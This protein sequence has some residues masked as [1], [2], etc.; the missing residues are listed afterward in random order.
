MSNFSATGGTL[1]R[2]LAAGAFTNIVSAAEVQWNRPL[3]QFPVTDMAAIVERL[4]DGIGCPVRAT[5]LDNRAVGSAAQYRLELSGLDRNR[6][7]W[8]AIARHGAA[9]FDRSIEESIADEARLLGSDSIQQILIFGG[10]S[11]LGDN[12]IQIIGGAE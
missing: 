6:L 8:A 3:G 4:G 7:A 11:Y 5:L 10:N 2:D 9:V 12:G 1:I